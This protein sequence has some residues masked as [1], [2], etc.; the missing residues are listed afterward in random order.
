MVNS[1]YL[2]PYARIPVFHEKFQV[3]VFDL[4]KYFISLRQI[5]KYFCIIEYDGAH[6]HLYYV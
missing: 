6:F 4:K 1:V 2:F 5:Q 3:F